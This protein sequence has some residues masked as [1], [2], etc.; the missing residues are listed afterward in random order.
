MKIQKNLYTVLVLLLVVIFQINLNA[1]TTNQP[2]ITEGPSYDYTWSRIERRAF[3]NDESTILSVKFFTKTMTLQGFDI[4]TLKPTYKKEFKDFPKKYKTKCFAK[5]GGK[6]SVIY[7]VLN[8]KP[9][10]HFDFFVRTIDI[11]NGIP[12][13]PIKLF[14]TSRL[15]INSTNGYV[16]RNFRG[17]SFKNKFHIKFSRDSSMFAVIY[18]LEFNKKLAG[19]KKEQF[20]VQVFDANFNK[21]WANE[22][23]IP[24]EIGKFNVLSFEVNKNGDVGFLGKTKPN[25]TY[26]FIK[27]PKAGIVKLKKL[28]IPNNYTFQHIS[29]KENAFGNFVASAYYLNHSLYPMKQS[30]I[31]NI[32]YYFEGIF[33]CEIDPNGTVVN[34]NTYKFPKEFA[35][36][37][38]IEERFV[39]KA[40]EH[41][42]KG[43]GG[44]RGLQLTNTQYLDN[45]NIIIV[46]EQI[47]RVPGS[48]PAYWNSY[49]RVIT[50]FSRNGELLSSK[51]TSNAGI[52]KYEFNEEK[53]FS[54]D[55]Q[56]KSLEITN[57][58][59][60]NQKFQIFKTVEFPHVE[61]LKPQDYFINDIVYINKNL[62]FVE[63]TADKK[64]R[65]IKVE[66]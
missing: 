59:T 66:L 28:D 1:Q 55:Y 33:N 23:T 6:V 31:S 43:Y 16:K 35:L 61:N 52:Y 41:Y 36:T 37:I 58:H 34:S 63:L 44:I 12:S 5:I 64:S 24:Y 3:F 51:E 29:L 47:V 32:G 7:S 48:E 42:A 25:T 21:L 26:S 14:G 38:E 9:E 40:R 56:S 18:K 22:F 54:F 30:S 8:K 49:H 19:G 50:K 4:K 57:W 60:K 10:K 11:K 53:L 17:P 45:G 65:L 27:V 39:K 46:G 20:G 62:F 13:K 15:A 2:K